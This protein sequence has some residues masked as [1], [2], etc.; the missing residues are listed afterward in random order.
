ML[1]WE[2][3]RLG[4]LSYRDIASDTSFTL[5]DYMTNRDV[6]RVP[7]SSTQYYLIENRQKI[8][9][10]DCAGGK[11]IY[12]YRVTYANQFPPTVFVECADGNWN[13]VVNTTQ[14][15]VTRTT[16]NPNSKN[17]INFYTDIGSTRYACNIPFYP[18]NA[19]WGDV[20]DPFNLLYNDVFSPA[21]NPPF[22]KSFASDPNF[23]IQ[24]NSKDAANNYTLQLYKTDIYAGKP[25]KPQNL[26]AVYNSSSQTIL[27]WNVNSE[28]DLS[29]YKIY[30]AKT[31]GVEPTSYNYLTTVTKPTITWTDN[32]I[33]VGDNT[34]KVFYKITAVDNSGKESVLSEYSYVNYLSSTLTANTTF[35]GNVITDRNVT[36]SGGITLSLQP[37]TQF[38]LNNGASL[39]VTGILNAIG[40]STNRITFDFIT[41][42]TTTQNGI[43]F[44]SGSSG[45][46]AFTTIKNG[47]YGVFCNGSGTM[48]PIN[49]C[50]ISNNTIGIFL[51][52]VG[53]PT[54]QIS[55]NKITA[56]SAY[57]IYMYNSF[58][59]N[60][61]YDTLSNCAYGFRCESGSIPYIY[62]NIIK[63]NSVGVFCTGASP[64][65][66]TYPN[67]DS[68]GHNVITANGTGISAAYGSNV[69][70]GFTNQRGMN[71]IYSNTS[72]AIVAAYSSVIKAQYNWWG[73]N[74]SFLTQNGGS[75]DTS[76]ALT[77]NPN[78][79]MGKASVMAN[80][81]PEGNEYEVPVGQVVSVSDTA[82][83]FDLEFEEAL[84]NMCKGNYENAIGQYSQKFK[85]EKN[86]RKRIYALEQLAEC[87]R[88]AEKND[89]IDFLGRDIRPGL[90]KNSELYAK[91]L[92]LENLF[93]ISDGK[94]EKA[95][96][97][98][99]T[100]RNNFTGNEGIYK[101]ALYNMW[102][103]YYIEQGDTVKAK[104]CFGELQTR[105]PDDDLTL[106][107]RV[108]LGE[109]DSPGR[110]TTPRGHALGKG[111]ATSKVEVPDTYALF[112]NYP[113]PFNPTT[114]IGYQIPEEGFVTIRIFDVIGREIST[115]V[116]Q[117]QKPG[118]YSVEFNGANLSSGMYFYQLRV[119][120]FVS[121]K[122]M[123]LVK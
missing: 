33:N 96:E 21:S 78:G 75:I 98:Y 42:N 57:G 99:T 119:N 90:S 92:E 5:T 80:S 113:N 47:Y 58:P 38:V 22:K 100:L 28:T 67:G 62:Y 91:T 23:S 7:L 88:L 3:Q 122:K 31:S 51:N 112:E 43:K 104:G 89:F 52:N 44:N 8:S 108:L 123:M 55:Y 40:S 74:P 39:L 56:N 34:W 82:Q 95:I 66:L 106:H 1:S 83:I 4:W 45:F 68:S 121:T 59:R 114:S 115:L 93:L 48:P 24:L 61:Y 14:Q 97:N 26:K 16:I 117:S 60:I 69:F 6:V 116:N 30:K 46:I 71:S 109:I 85:K 84:G 13:F 29:S 12:I 49:N 9:P 11:G 17:E 64:A 72:Y 18:T 120:D 110:F 27:T 87:H 102:Y 32:E 41:P 15:T 25:S 86:T 107:C 53:T 103:I 65:H 54:N 101:Q 77:S 10:H 118:K 37:G 70:L 105:Y 2:R 81:D 20:N 94:Y 50:T 19:A 73:T 76:H 111:D 79:G 35:T 63:N 36:V